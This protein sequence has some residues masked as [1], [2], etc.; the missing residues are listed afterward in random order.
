MGGVYCKNIEALATLLSFFLVPQL[1]LFLFNINLF[2]LQMPRALCN[3]REHE[4]RPRHDDVG[5]A[6]PFEAVGGNL[7]IR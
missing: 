3:Q 2:L 6:Q 7:E 4:T 1:R 5:A